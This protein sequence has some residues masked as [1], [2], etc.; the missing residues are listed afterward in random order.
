MFGRFQ[1]LIKTRIYWHIS[2]KLSTNKCREYTFHCS[3]DVT[4][5]QTDG[6]TDMVKLTSSSHNFSLWKCQTQ[7]IIQNSLH[8]VLTKHRVWIQ[9]K[10]RSLNFHRVSL[11]I[12]QQSA[13][14][15]EKYNFWNR[16]WAATSSLTSRQA[17]KHGFFTTSFDSYLTARDTQNQYMNTGITDNMPLNTKNKI[18]GTNFST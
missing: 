17:K 3:R 10:F 8:S 11:N 7:G 14:N 5:R 9:N 18:Y 12:G 1:I 13:Y 15:V 4:C 16:T 6:Q 2:V